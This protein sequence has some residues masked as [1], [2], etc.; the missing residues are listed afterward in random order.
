MTSTIET[1]AIVGGGSVG[2]SFLYQ[3]LQALTKGRHRKPRILI[4]EP[5]TA[6]GPGGAYQDDQASN[7]LNIPAGSMSAIASERGDFVRWLQEQP[8]D[9]LARFDVQ[10]VNPA[11][12][13]PRPLFGI[14]MRD[15]Y[16]RAAMLAKDLEIEL[17]HVRSAVISLRTLSAGDAEGAIVLTAENGVGYCASRVVLCNGNLPSVSFP[18]L[19]AIDQFLNSPYPVKA[20]TDRIGRDD[21]VGIL[22]SSLSAIDAVVA[23]QAAG[24]RGRIVCVSRGGRLPSVRSPRNPSISLR[25]FGEARL[26]RILLAGRSEVTLVE[27]SEM[28]LDALRRMGGTFDREDVLGFDG[29]AHESL[30]REIDASLA[31]PRPWQAVA[32]STNEHVET[33][34]R[35]LGASERQRFLREWKGL[36]MARRATFPLRNALKIQT[37]FA[38]GQLSVLNGFSGAVYDQDAG[39]FSLSRRTESGNTESVS[40]DWLV[41]ATSFSTDVS[42]TS[43]RLIRSLIDQRL[44]TADPCGGI[45][46]DFDTGCVVMPNGARNDRIS[47]LGSLATGTYFWTASM[48]INARL[49]YGQA[50]H[51][52]KGLDAASLGDVHQA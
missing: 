28:L 16:R 33:I 1:I 27:V 45:Q 19:M 43:D 34:W 13:Y 30:D 35:A 31:G 44:A 5:Q 18:E 23:L 26:N 15:V 11:D 50:C 32:S 41:N 20:L 46:L 24:H 39:Q 7:L 29:S 12:F 14:Y 49:A 17:V 21:V 8:A 51:V 3:L 42:C 40:C 48:E 25:D 36:W 52:A 10:G 2:T 22:G 4:F 37:L 47:L 6:I 38:D 9:L